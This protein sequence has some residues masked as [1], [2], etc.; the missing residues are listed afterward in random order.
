MKGIV[1]SLFLVLGVFV[2]HATRFSLQGTIVGNNGDAIE[3]ATVTLQPSGMVMQTDSKGRFT[4]KAEEGNYTVITSFI[5]YS[6]NKVEVKLNQNKKIRIRLKENSKVLKEVVVTAKEGAGLTSTSRIDRDAMTH[7]QPTSFTDLLELLPGHVSQ[8]PDMSTVNSIQL[9]ETGTMGATGAKTKN[10]DFDITSLGTMFV[11]DGAPINEDA[12]MQNVP[13]ASRNQTSPEHKRDATNK[14]VDMRTISTDNIESV[15]IVRGIPSAEY[16]NLTSGLVNIKRI[17][18]AT[19]LTARFKADEYSKLLSVGKGFYLG[20]TDHIMNVDGGF[21]DSKADPRNNFENYKRLN[22]SSRFNFRWN[23]AAVR[24]H[25]VTSIDYTG[26]FDN[27]KNDPDISVAKIDEYQSN[28]NRIAY[29]GDL[30]INVN[31][32]PWFNHLNLNTSVSYE[33]NRLERRKIVAPQRASV[34]P[35]TLDEGVQDG[36]YL[37]REYIAHYVSDGKPLSIFLKFKGEGVFNIWGMTNDYKIGGDWSM[38]KNYGDGQVYELDKPL[39]A[40]WTTR[41]RAYKTIPALHTLSWYVEDHI[42]GNI[43]NNKLEV[44][45]GLRSIQMPGLAQRYRMNGRIYLDPRLNGKWTFPIFNIDGQRSVLYVAGGYGLTT[46]MP[47]TSYLFPQV[48]YSD[49]IQLNYYDINHPKEYSRINLRTYIDDVTNYRLK[50]AI[51][52]KWEVRIGGSFGKNHFSIT[53]FNEKMTSGFRYSAFYQPY[54]FRK[55]DATTIKPESLTGPPE[56]DNLPYEEVKVL[57]GY[58]QA[59][60]GSRLDKEGIEFVVNTARWTPLATALTITG[61]WFH[62][63]Y[64]NSQMLFVPVSDVI[65]NKAVRDRYI[66]YYDCNTGRVND[67]FNTNFM[68]DTQITRWGLVFSTSFQCLW[69]TT[70]KKLWQNGVPDYYL[71]VKDGLLHPYT[72]AMKND[73]ELQFLVQ[74]YSDALYKRQTTPIAVYVNL[75][76]TKQIGKHMKIAV[77]ANRLLDY[78]PDYKSNGLVIRRMT[79]PYFGMELNFTL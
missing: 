26:S 53:Y 8:T 25:W 17:R 68:F 65:N 39:S 70:T 18:K 40:S 49:F 63:T 71:D 58:S 50:P 76:A 61:A 59:T 20:A 54:A 3:F 11:V 35:T 32:N 34:A 6:T 78:L 69:F 10:A 75:K 9:R 73:T 42:T 27:V 41:P 66:G 1:L 28:Y 51:N 62:S 7:L 24:T 31:D 57:D 79:N 77:F 21:L 29:T 5:G 64:T 12:N 67:Q 30:N 19:P 16:G 48:H 45:L 14:G 60:N 13:G 52:R 33:A 43:G 56:L 46:K 23:N 38:T 72:E 44:Q 47:T 4:F 37:L 22:V 2:A 15:E 74:N 36:Q 55:Y